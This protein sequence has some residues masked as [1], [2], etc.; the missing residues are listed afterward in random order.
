MMTGAA[1]IW[2]RGMFGTINAFN[3][4]ATENFPSSANFEIGFEK[5][6]T[7]RAWNTFLA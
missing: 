5:R 2:P 3:C 4:G 6:H 1:G 7:P